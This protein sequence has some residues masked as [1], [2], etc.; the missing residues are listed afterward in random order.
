MSERALNDIIRYMRRAKESLRVA[1]ELA[2]KVLA[3]HLVATDIKVLRSDLSDCITELDVN[4]R[5]SHYRRQ[6]KH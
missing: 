6:R 1:Q 5:Q 3:N 2:D 4:Y